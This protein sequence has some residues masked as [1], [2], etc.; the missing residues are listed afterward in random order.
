M[1]RRLPNAEPFFYRAGDTGCLLLHGFT[2]SPHELR[3]LGSYLADRGI[4][5]S[6][7]LLPGHG[8]HPDDLRG[9]GWRDWY[10]AASDAL[11]G[12]QGECRRV[13]V[14]GLSLGGALALHMAAQREGDL[15]GFVAMSAPVLFP[16]GLGRLLLAL[17][18]GIRALHKPLRDIQ[19][20]VARRLH[21]SYGNA[22]L[23]ATASVVDFA[24]LVRGELP[25]VKVPALVL[26]A[27]RDHVVHP[28][29]A[30]LIYARLGS[31]RKYLVVLR[32]GFHIVTVD[33]DKERVFRAVAAFLKR[34]VGLG[35]REGEG[36]S[37]ARA[38]SSV[39]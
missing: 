39:V 5:V 36:Q 20:P 25:Q 16:P 2:S 24:G 23:D 32:R 21:V 18:P 11:D 33:R 12:L 22:P 7:P 38:S 27:R 14:A 19:D 10:G 37:V 35:P 26:Y 34:G 30:H 9:L 6:A 17:Q 31:E 3:E 13:A 15:A 8:T 29:N 28:L 1:S 4:T